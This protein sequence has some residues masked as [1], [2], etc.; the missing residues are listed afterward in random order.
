MTKDGGKVSWLRISGEGAV[1]VG[2]ILLAFA[3]DA[4]WERSQERGQEIRVL[5]ALLTEFETNRTNQPSYMG[6]HR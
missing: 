5:E 2:S 6:R 3:I 4:A 1:I